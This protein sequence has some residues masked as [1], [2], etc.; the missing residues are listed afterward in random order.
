MVQTPTRSVSLEEFLSL[1]ETKPASQY[2]DG[3]IFQKPMPQGKHSRLQ[4][5]FSTVINSAVR[6]KKIA[7]AFPELRCTFSGS[8]IVLDIAVFTWHRIPTDTQGNIANVFPIS[9][10]W[11]IE[12]LSLRQRPT[13]VTKNILRCLDSG[14]EMGWLIDPEGEAVLIYRAAQ[15]T[16][17]VDEPEQILPMPKFMNE[18]N[19]RV[20]DLFGLL[21]L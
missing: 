5:D 20:V 12:I 8:S 16:V 15:A 21:K 13:K 11:T 10:D 3:Q 14:A 17:I 1:P 7:C 4:L 2:V 18:M 6:Q 19:Y 9:P